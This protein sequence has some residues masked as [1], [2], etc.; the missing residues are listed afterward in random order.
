MLI[1]T[2]PD[3]R[4]SP[5]VRTATSSLVALGLAATLITHA[6]AAGTATSATFGVPVAAVAAA[7]AQPNVLLVTVDDMEVSDLQRMPRLKRL[8]A[9]GTDVTQGL[10]PT[11]ICSPSRASMLTG[12]Y[13]H[14][15]GVHTVEGRHGG[16]KAFRDHDTLPVWLSRAG[17]RT[18]FAGKY[19]NGYGARRPHYVP[20]G[21][22]DWYGAV[23][24]STYSYYRT[25]FNDDGRLVS[26]YRHNSDV[27]AD[28]TVGLIRRGARPSAK[29]WFTWVN[30]TAPHSG[31]P[32]EVDDPSRIG[33]P[34]PAA[35]HRNRFR[36]AAL[37]RVPEMLRGGGSPW[38]GRHASSRRRAEM[39]EAHQQRAES[40][41]SV[42]E[43]VGR[44]VTTLKRTG[45]WGRTYV[46]FTSDNGFLVGH[47]NVVGKLVPYDRSIRIPFYV[48]GPGIPRGRSSTAATVADLPVTIAAMTGASVGRRVDGVNML[49]FWRGAPTYER[50]I[51]IEGW[52]VHNG[53]RRIYAGIRMGDLTYARLRKGREV[54]F[55]RSRDPGELRN[56]VRHPAYRDDA[57]HLRALTRRYRDCRG[58]TCPG[59]ETFRLRQ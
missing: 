27:L 45:Q 13:A 43:A 40:L 2:P 42:D 54:L 53:Q 20:P 31:G 41:L 52:P 28:H 19:I 1:P 15:H 18:Q 59:V 29:P 39:R 21:W 55:D 56:V 30:F 38:A 5:Y 14:S 25:K 8:V 37:P 49:P 7:P 33:T 10:A 4:R 35:R 17:Y 57:Q 51:P 6:P 44:M 46:V 48:V 12:Q 50:P 32:H 34:M 22:D 58:T 26:T 11:P 24:G 9:G 36:G 23:G 47:H 3:Q 16:F